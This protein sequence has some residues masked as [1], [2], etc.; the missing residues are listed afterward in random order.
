MLGRRTRHAAG[1][2]AKG[3]GRRGLAAATL[4]ALLTALVLVLPSIASAHIERASYWPTHSLTTGA[5]LRPSA[6]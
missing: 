3:S 4:A 2:L 1:S 6:S 5:W